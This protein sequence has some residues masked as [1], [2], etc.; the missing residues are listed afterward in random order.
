MLSL[1][2]N[3]A[4]GINEMSTEYV[5]RAWNKVRYLFSKVRKFSNNCF[6]CIAILKKINKIKFLLHL[7]LGDILGIMKILIHRIFHSIRQ[8]S[9]P[10]NG[11]GGDVCASYE[12][13]IDIKVHQPPSAHRQVGH[14]LVLEDGAKHH[15]EE[16]SAVVHWQRWNDPSGS[17]SCWRLERSTTEWS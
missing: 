12:P 3:K 8:S 10:N 11:G 7:V 16:L 17:G 6:K 5:E 13:N 15:R 2:N 1:V 9:L 14:Q 4:T